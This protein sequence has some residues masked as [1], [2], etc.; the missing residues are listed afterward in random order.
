MSAALD[1]SY[2][3]TY[4][5]TVIEILGLARIVQRLFEPIWSVG[6]EVVALTRL[7]GS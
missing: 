5:F 3:R 6:M 2:A 4:V 7:E 1:D